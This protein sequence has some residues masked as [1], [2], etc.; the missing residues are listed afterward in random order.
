MSVMQ[1]ELEAQCKKQYFYTL[2]H[3]RVMF[4]FIFAVK[5][6]KK[7]TKKKTLVL[8]GRS[9]LRSDVIVL[10]FR[11]TNRRT[12]NWIQRSAARDER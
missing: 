4:V 1:R 6:L 10:T 7:Q 2:R 9:F 5:K 12:M 8:R 11:H 3:E